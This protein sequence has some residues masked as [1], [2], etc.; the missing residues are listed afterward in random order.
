VVKL[1]D[2]SDLGSGGEIRGGSSPSSRTI[3]SKEYIK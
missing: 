1:A 2:T 3:N